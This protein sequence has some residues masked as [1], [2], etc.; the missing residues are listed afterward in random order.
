LWERALT[1]V[2][3]LKGK[4]VN[5]RK[6]TKLIEEV[7]TDIHRRIGVPLCHT[8]PS[9]QGRNYDIRLITSWLT[10]GSCH[11][12]DILTIVGISGIGKT[13][14]A[15]YVFRLHF[16]KFHKSSFIEDINTRCKEHHNG[17]LDLQ[18]QLHGDIS[19]KIEL[20]VND[21]TMYTS[22]IESVLSRKRVFIVLDD[23]GSLDQLNALLGKN[24]LHP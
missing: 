4:A 21:V 8:L 3:D 7:V 19:K 6:E 1:Q 22:K 23:I 10:D 2:A 14:L 15:K 16:G 24:G 11:T 17:L 13:S 12:I 9:L 5:G 18:K 20:H